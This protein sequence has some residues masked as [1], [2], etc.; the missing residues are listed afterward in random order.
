MLS[1]SAEHWD[2]AYALGETTR[3]WYQQRARQSMVLFERGGVT[4]TD[5]VVDVGGGASV[6]VDDLLARGFMDL[7]VLDISASALLLARQRLGASASAVTWLTEDLLR[8]TPARTFDVWHDR[9]VLHFLTDRRDR[10]QYCSVLES[11]TAP[12]SL[13]IIAAFAPDGPDRCSGLPVQRYGIESI[14]ALLGPQWS[15][16]SD[17]REVHTTPSGAAQPFTWAVFRRVTV[18]APSGRGP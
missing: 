1:G 2:G 16:V 18:K 5:S 12:G 17:D 15:L 3:S 9:A 10:N 7:T 6:L 4:S 14:R 8:W 11:A 13:A